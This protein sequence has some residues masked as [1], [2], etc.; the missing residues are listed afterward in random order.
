M[1]SFDETTVDMEFRFQM[2]WIIY[3][4]KNRKLKTKCILFNT[5][6]FKILNETFFPLVLVFGANIFRFFGSYELKQHASIVRVDL[7]T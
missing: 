1:V 7:V 2:V 5:S 4:A 6:L 3:M